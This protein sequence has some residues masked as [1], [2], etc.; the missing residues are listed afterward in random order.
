MDKYFTPTY[1]PLFDV[2]VPDLTDSSGLIGEG[3]FEGWDRML[4]VLKERKEERKDR[5]RREKE[6]RHEERER[7]RR[8]RKRRKEG[9]SPE[10]VERTKGLMEVE[11][12][13]KRGGVREWDQGKVELS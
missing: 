12:Y 13:A 9:A 7:V 3:A 2:S 10:V 5:E 6:M 4:G 8:E 1:D 11:G